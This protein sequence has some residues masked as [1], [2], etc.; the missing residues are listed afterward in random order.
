MAERLTLL[1]SGGGT[2]M[3][4]MIK[5][6]QVRLTLKGKIEIAAVISDNPKAG[7]MDK[8]RGLGISDDDIVFVDPNRF[9]NGKGE[10]D[11]EGFGQEMLRQT[12]LR[13]TTVITQNGY[14]S[15]TSP[16][17]ISA[18]EGAI[19]NQH[20][21]PKHETRAMRGTQPHAVMLRI[22]QLTGRNEGSEVTAHR[23]N[24]KW[25]DGPTVG[26]EHVLIE[27]VWESPK[28]LQAR[29][30]PL[31]HS[32]QIALLEQVVRGDVRELDATPAYIKPGEEG[33]LAQAR[34]DARRDFPDG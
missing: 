20:P 32:L 2:T 3:A 25:D 17:L 34:Q 28:D 18:Y 1:I 11:Q 29:A 19:F 4:E 13:G 30:L 6:V 31:E 9:K 26:I 7:G 10:I 15:R 27:D 5:A 12:R 16:V 14:L 22:A 23:V 33:I 24:E 8:A 21:G